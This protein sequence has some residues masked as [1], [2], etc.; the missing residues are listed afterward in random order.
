MKEN[1]I[2]KTLKEHVKE[3]D[4]VFV[5]PTQIAASLWADRI[6]E[7][8]DCTAVAMGRFIAW[9]KFKGEAV[10]GENQSINSCYDEK[11]FCCTA[12]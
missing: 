4:A 1:L 2:E 12:Y 9:D 11:H 8:S 7:I 10:R 6:I 3:R 5:F